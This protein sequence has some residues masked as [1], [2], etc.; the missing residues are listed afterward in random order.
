VKSD[1]IPP[2]TSF[3]AINPT[4]CCTDNAILKQTKAIFAAYLFSVLSF[5]LWFRADLA[6]RNGVH[7]L[8]TNLHFILDLLARLPLQP[9]PAEFKSAPLIPISEYSLMLMLAG[10]AALAA[11]AGLYFCRLVF[12][13]KAEPRWYVVPGIICFC[14]LFLSAR[15]AY[16]AL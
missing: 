15:L 2:D 5:L 4:G 13:A 9:G 11:L 14:L 10:L 8:A 12:K 3:F 16:W 6:F 1:W 7:V